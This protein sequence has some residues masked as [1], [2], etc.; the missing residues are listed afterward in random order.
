MTDTQGA[1]KKRG[2]PAGSKNKEA[3]PENERAKE[4]RTNV[5]G[6]LVLAHLRDIVAAEEKKDLAVI[7]LRSAR[8]RAKCDGVDLKAL[9]AARYLALLDDHEVVSAFNSVSTYA[10]YLG[11][12]FYHQFDLFDSPSAAEEA[13]NERAFLKGI[14]AGRLGQGEADNP[15]DAS[16]VAGQEWI[17]GHREGQERLLAGI[18]ELGSA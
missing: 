1:A 16:S 10:K 7:A 5:S 3:K 14:K 2:R 6:D 11:V 12:E 9:D 17:R 18:K 8:K 4:T 13:V 15:Y